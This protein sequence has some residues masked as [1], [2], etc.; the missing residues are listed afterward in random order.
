[1]SKPIIGITAMPTKINAGTAL[2]RNIN[3]Q[4]D[5]VFEMITEFGGIPL[6]IPN[7]MPSSDISVLINKLDGLLL[8]GGQDVHP[9]SYDKELKIRYGQCQDLTGQPFER[10]M[11]FEPNKSR[12]TLEIALY[13]AAKLKSMPVLGICR[14]MQIINVAEGGTLY[15]ELP[16]NSKL[17]AHE[18]EKEGYIHH[19]SVNIKND[20]LIHE[21]FGNTTYITASSHHQ[22]IECLASELVASGIADDGIIEFI[23]N[24][25]PSCFIVGIQGH[26]E[27]TRFNYPKYNELVVRFINECK[28]GFPSEC[29]SKRHNFESSSSV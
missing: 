11:S 7:V 13:K 6:L 25:D 21:V 27:K 29:I 26:F 3:F 8:S 5:E 1:M 10:P 20:T 15:Q 12:D 14:G 2:A 9:N 18:L 22:A 19:H 17:L 28:R 23:E 24:K 4:K 16:Q